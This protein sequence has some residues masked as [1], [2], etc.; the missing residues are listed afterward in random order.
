MFAPR[1][2]MAI[3]MLATVAAAAT[4]FASAQE[5]APLSPEVE[6]V[7]NKAVEAM[8]GKEKLNSI[9]SSRIVMISS[10]MGQESTVEMHWKKPNM[11]LSEMEMPGFGKMT[12]GCDGKVAWSHNPASGYMLMD[13]AMMQMSSF[14]NPI[15]SLRS[16]YNPLEY[17]GAE[18]FNGKKCDK[19]RGVIKNEEGGESETF[20]FFD[21]KTGLMEG[22]K[23]AFEF[24][25]GQKMESVSKMSDYKEVD[26]CMVAHT[27][28]S[29]NMGMTSTMTIK[30]IEFNKV[31]ASKFALPDEV[32]KMAA[33]AG[34]GQ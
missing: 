11:F 32:K 12:S 27:T 8:G 18:D 10:S 25:P 22:T 15:D 1:K 30:E 5:P 26:G 6:K 23:T 24:Q 21:Q 34:G 4:S 9:E 16:T 2:R 19:I 29:E 13:P 33:E 7:L 20:I 28:T 17:A 3:L 14:G 31:D